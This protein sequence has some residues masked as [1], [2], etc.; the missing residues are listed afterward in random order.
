M[1]HTMQAKNSKEN[2]HGRAGGMLEK[3]SPG[4]KPTVSL[5]PIL[6]PGIKMAA[7]SML[8]LGE[9]CCGGCIC[10]VWITRCCH[11]IC[12]DSDLRTG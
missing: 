12:H 1:T 8:R 6:Q 5:G 4:P 7:G 9:N 11:P 10:V 2:A 3:Q